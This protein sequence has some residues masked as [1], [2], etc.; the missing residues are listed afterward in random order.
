ML[1]HYYYYYSPLWF[2]AL[3]TSVFIL[4]FFYITGKIITHRH[5]SK[6]EMLATLLFIPCILLSIS[7]SFFSN[8]GP[9]NVVYSSIPVIGGISILILSNYK[10]ETKSYLVKFFILLIFFAPF[11]YSTALSAW[12]DTGYD[13]LPKQANVEIDGGFGKGIRTNVVYRN[14]YDWIR[15]TTERYTTK[16]DYII[17]YVV[18]PMV[19]MIAKRR[20]ALSDTWIDFSVSIPPEYWENAITNMEKSGRDPKI[21]FVFDRRPQIF[22]LPVTGLKEPEYFAWCGQ[23]IFP[24]PF[25]DLIS[26]YVAEHMHQIDTFRMYDG[27]FVYCYQR[28]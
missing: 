19:Y 16:D 5:V 10:I 23:E 26:K 20:P 15:Y 4:F 27:V 21:A 6:T 25:S 2:S 11:Y 3:I 12:R 28:N 8:V 9:C 18:S 14:L 13:V 24:S 22:P 17:S 1:P 7:M